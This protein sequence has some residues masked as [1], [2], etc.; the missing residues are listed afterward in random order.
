MSV[1][2][3]IT[4]TGTLQNILSGAPDAGTLMVM[5]AGFG[6]QIPRI[7]GTSLLDAIAPLEVKAANDGTFSFTLFGNDVITP[8]PNLTYYTILIKDSRGNVSQLNAYQFA[9]SGSF[10]L[11]TVA[12]YM[13]VPPPLGGISPVLKNPPGESLQTI[14]GSITIEGNL[15][16]T[17]TINGNTPGI[18]QVTPAAAVVFDGSLGVSFA[19][20]LNQNTTS[21]ATNM[22][23]FRRSLVA[24]KITQGGSGPFTF[25]W[26][27]TF[28]NMGVVLP[29]AG[30]ITT[31]LVNISADGSGDAAAPAMYSN[32]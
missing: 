16:V 7:N 28:R 20:T 24:F 9:G 23:T 10:D 21:S 5:L 22:A 6:S 25:A 1:L 18:V 13:P 26:P 27:S 3:Q 11:S 17:G 19:L 31:Q 15:I 4:I 29:V 12:P 8:G 30:A 14:D 2:P 32:T